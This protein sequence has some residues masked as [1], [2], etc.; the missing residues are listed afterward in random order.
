MKKIF[1]LIDFY[2]FV[3][4]I[5]LSLS[6]VYFEVLD[7]KP[8]EDNSPIISISPQSETLRVYRNEEFN[9]EIEI[10]RDWKIAEFPD[11]QLGPIFN[12]YPPETFKNPP[13][14]HFSE[15][16]QVS[17]FPFGIPTEGISGEYTDAKLELKETPLQAINFL[18]KNGSAWA[19]F[20]SFAN[21]PSSW[22]E[23]GFIFAGLEIKDLTESCLRNN[24]Q[25]KLEACDPFTGD[26]I[27][28]EGEIDSSIRVQEEAILKSFRF[29]K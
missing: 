27:I 20:I 1:S 4:I 18:M 6:Y 7:F 23:S 14:I 24:Q 12:F 17:V 11:N 15:V 16:N 3:A 5:F 26:L 13:F 25:I 8:K 28:K 9:F 22:Q 29:T 19:T 2:T 10:P 21:K